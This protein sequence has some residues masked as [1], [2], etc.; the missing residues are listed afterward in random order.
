MAT[1]NVFELTNAELSKSLSNT[2]AK[3]GVKESVKK[4][5]KSKKRTF[6]KISVDK[7]RVESLQ[8][9]EDA[10]DEDAGVD[11]TPEDDVVLVI[12]PEMEET[13][14]STEDAEAA[15]EELV[16]DYVCK[17]AI[18]GANY[19]C[20]HDAVNEDLESEESECPICGETGEQIVVGEITPSEDSVD[21]DETESET[22]EDEVSDDDFA[23][24]DFSEFDDEEFADEPEEDEDYEESISRAKRRTQ[25]RRESARQP[26][27]KSSASVK[28]SKSTS[29]D[30]DEVTLNRML[31][32]FAKENYENVR[33]VKITS[34]KCKG[35]QL[36]LEGTVVT[37]KGS[38][39]PTKFVCEDF[40]PSQ[41]IHARFTEKG[42][43]TE[44][45]VSKGTS[46]IVDFKTAKNVI[47]PVALKYSYKVKERRDVYHVSGK[48]L[49]ESAKKPNRK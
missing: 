7:I 15:A 20:D 29:Y 8:F 36:T 22:E 4:T 13:P 19:V 24:D 27:R 44:N 30:F 32:K 40:K 26:M 45:A 49:S 18:C 41:N 43:F 16:G 33:F 1:L 6:E 10:E 5:A 25:M 48:V 28:K 34:A 14:E 35:T 21:A 46:F 31:T 9:V 37:K 12:D 38:R 17:C 23:D 47:T 42:A 39:R 11:Y 3:K 2:P